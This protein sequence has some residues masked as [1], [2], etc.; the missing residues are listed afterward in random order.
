M[1]C[2]RHRHFRFAHTYTPRHNESVL[3]HRIDDG[4]KSIIVKPYTGLPY[5]YLAT[6]VCSFISCPSRPEH[7]RIQVRGYF[8][9]KAN[10]FGC[11]FRSIDLKIE[12]KNRFSLRNILCTRVGVLVFS[13]SDR[14]CNSNQIKSIKLECKYILLEFFFVGF[15]LQLYIHHIHHFCHANK[16]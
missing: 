8:A 12:E 16:N 7:P 15:E 10:F 4:K 13:F 5:A 3:Q 14:G 9:E 2:R 6:V 1:C 11:N